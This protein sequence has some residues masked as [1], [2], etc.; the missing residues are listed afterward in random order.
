MRA[1]PRAGPELRTVAQ[2]K[3]M[4]RP[5][6]VVHGLKPALIPNPDPPHRLVIRLG[7][8]M[9]MRREAE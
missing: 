5:N 7:V 1:A 8:I 4:M 6:P 3:L 2:M 9:E